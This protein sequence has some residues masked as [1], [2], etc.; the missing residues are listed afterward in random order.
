MDTAEHVHD[1]SAGSGVLGCLILGEHPVSEQ[2]ACAGVCLDQIEDGLSCSLNLLRSKRSEDTVV[3]RIVQ[4]QDLSGLYE[5]GNQR[6]ESRIDQDVNTAL[7]EYQ[8]A[9]HDRSDHVEA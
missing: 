1:Q 5:D 4:E 9:C 7:Q 3:D 6:K 8:N 2:D